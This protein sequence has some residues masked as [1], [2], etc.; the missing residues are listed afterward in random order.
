MDTTDPEI[1]FDEKGVSNHCHEFDS[2]YNNEW[3]PNE[4]GKNILNDILEKIKKEGRGN[5]YNC[6]IGLSGGIDSSYLA[7]AKGMTW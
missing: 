5:K 6:I 3:F 7:L 2:L 1:R 4:K